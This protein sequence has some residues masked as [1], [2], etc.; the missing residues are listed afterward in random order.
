MEAWGG[1]DDWDFEFEPEI[2]KQQPVKVP[3]QNHYDYGDDNDNHDYGDGDD[4]DDHD[5]G[6]GD[7]DNDHE[8][9]KH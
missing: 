4:N 2:L 5:N 6:N 1:N 3:A 8:I 9:L 7:D